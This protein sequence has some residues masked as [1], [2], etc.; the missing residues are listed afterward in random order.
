M[1]KMSENI[2]LKK[3]LKDN[4]RQSKYL[5]LRHNYVLQIHSY[6]EKNNNF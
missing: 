6:Y 2:T 3:I 4:H 5:K 1:V